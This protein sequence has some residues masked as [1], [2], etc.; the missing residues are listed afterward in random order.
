MKGIKYVSNKIKS[1][2][3]KNSQAI[4]V[5]VPMKNQPAKT[6][7]PIHPANLTN[8]AIKISAD[9]AIIT[10]IMVDEGVLFFGRQK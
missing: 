6:Q 2:L 3:T 7:A 1:A 5:E 9:P 10:T 8:F 4:I